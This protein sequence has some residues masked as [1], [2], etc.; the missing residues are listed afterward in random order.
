MFQGYEMNFLKNN[1]IYRLNNIKLIESKYR[2]LIRTIIDNDNLKEFLL[3][4]NPLLNISYNHVSMNTNNIKFLDQY[5][6]TSIFQSNKNWNIQITI[7]GY[8]SSPDNEDITPIWKINEAKMCVQEKRPEGMTNAI[9]KRKSRIHKK[10]MKHLKNGFI[11]IPKKVCKTN[12]ERQR[13]YK[14][15]QKTLQPAKPIPKTNAEHQR[16]YRERLKQL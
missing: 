16:M 6:L 14:I 7:Q 2:Y 1:I 12:A 15:K 9:R 10:F 13:L 3:K 5:G 8:K 11:E 4:I